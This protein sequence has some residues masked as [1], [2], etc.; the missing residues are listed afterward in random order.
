[1][2][3]SIISNMK[4]YL[5]LA[6][7]LIY[8]IYI[9]YNWVHWSHWGVQIWCI[10][11]YILR[12]YRV[13]RSMNLTVRWKFFIFGHI[14]AVLGSTEVYDSSKWRPGRVQFNSRLRQMQFFEIK[15]FE[16]KRTSFLYYYTH[17]FEWAHSSGITWFSQQSV[18]RCY[19]LLRVRAFCDLY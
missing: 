16:K 6:L 12:V 8:I 10:T 11:S 19:C 5:P 3:S 2:T 13:Y 7:I 17:A 14:S 1:M 18:H 4:L 9:T 15:K